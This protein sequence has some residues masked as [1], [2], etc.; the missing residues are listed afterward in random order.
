[1]A[2]FFEEIGRIVTNPKIASEWSDQFWY[3]QALVRFRK[4]V[5]IDARI[6]KHVRI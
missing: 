1:M 5:S 2:D 3:R 6:C 4:I